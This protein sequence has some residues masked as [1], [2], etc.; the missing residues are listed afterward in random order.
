MKQLLVYFVLT[1]ASVQLFAQT[2]LV[3]PLSPDDTAR[4]KR[5]HQEMLDAI[6]R[7]ND[8]ESEVRDKYLILDKSDPD[9]GAE[10]V[11]QDDSLNITSES[12]VWFASD[13]CGS[14]CK[15]YQQERESLAKRVRKGWERSQIY[16]GEGHTL[17]FE[18]TRDFK[19]IVPSSPPPPVKNNVT[20]MP[21]TCHGNICW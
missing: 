8:I 12:P 14:G 17:D 6:K 1:M 10:R 2:A 20:L 18:F 9:A 16:V 4:Y 5:V 3:V 7:W 21:Q 13:T 19:F 15:K 11:Y